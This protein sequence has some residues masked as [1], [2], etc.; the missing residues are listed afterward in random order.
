MR[1]LSLVAMAA[2]AAVAAV[3]NMLQPLVSAIGKAAQATHSEMDDVLKA[4]I[5]AHAT[6]KPYEVA[7]AKAGVRPERGLPPRRLPLASASP[8]LLSFSLA[9]A[10]VRPVQQQRRRHGV[11]RGLQGRS[12]VTESRRPHPPF[13]EASSPLQKEPGWRCAALPDGVFVPKYEADLLYSPASA[14][15]MGLVQ[16]RER[17]LVLSS[18]RSRR[19]GSWSSPTPTP[20]WI[21]TRR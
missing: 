17:V 1:V 18:A 14:V 10:L 16:A 7:G 3:A 15:Q 19:P 21:T 5:E 11:R 9:A 12:H 20:S 4:A 2:A 13:A 8:L 6:L